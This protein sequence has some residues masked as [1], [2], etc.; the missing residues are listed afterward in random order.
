M[1]QAALHV[2]LIGFGRIAELVH[3]R[4]LT[5]LPHVYVAAVAEQDAARRKQVWLRSPQTGTFDD[6]HSMLRDAKI[7]AVVI[8]LPP[9]QH[10]AAAIAAFNAGKHVY[11]EK[12]ITPSLDEAEA[13]RTAWRAS[14]KIGMMGFNFRYH[15]LYQQAKSVI[16]SGQ[17]GAVIG[18]RGVFTTPTRQLPPWK[19]TRATGGGVLLDLASHHVDIVHDIFGQEIVG[20]SALEHSQRVE[21]DNATL[22]LRLASG[23]LIQSFFS[24]NSISEHRFEIYLE[25]A[26]LV[27]DLAAPD[28][29]DIYEG[30]TYTS[31]KGRLQR[32]LATL[33]PRNLLRAA[34]YEPSFARSLGAFAD[35]VRLNTAA[36]PDL[37]D[38]YRC[39]QVIIAAE[40]A[41]RSDATVSLVD[42]ANSAPL[43]V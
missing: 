1:G 16:Q 3:L 27:A 39:L 17:Y 42:S 25:R 15:P 24:M 28:A 5:G 8:C 43:P 34:G 9:A 7:G 37:D 36:K 6:Y 18:A 10:A 20:V 38:G 11:L 21:A 14:G 4:V 2:G 32:G 19:Q 23:A 30:T 29:L 13:V 31:R 12:P 40:A 33:A 35:A 41:A 26:K 22:Q